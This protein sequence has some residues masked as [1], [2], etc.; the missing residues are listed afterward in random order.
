MQTCD[1]CSNCNLY[2]R[3]EAVPYVVHESDM[4]RME[5]ANKR[6]HHWNIVLVVL[7]AILFAVILIQ[8]NM[9]QKVTETTVTDVWQE[10][11]NS[12]TN[13][14]VGGDYYGGETESEDGTYE[15]VLP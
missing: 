10:S 11:D 5:R 13:R 1:D 15:D 12:S 3:N 6:A 7:I 14:F 8:N 9:Y 2:A 4:A